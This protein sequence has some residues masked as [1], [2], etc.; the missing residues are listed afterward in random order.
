MVAAAHGVPP[1]WV[2]TIQGAELWAFQMALHNVLFPSHVFTD[3]K[4]VQVGVRQEPQWLRASKRRYARIW[5]VIHA[6][7]DDGASANTMVW[8]PAHTSQDRVGEAQCSDGLVLS[9]DMWQANRM[10]DLLAKEAA[11]RVRQPPATRKWIK[12]HFKRLRDVA[13]FVGQL[14]YEAG[15]HVSPDGTVVRD[16]VGVA[17]M[18]RSAKRVPPQSAVHLGGGLAGEPASG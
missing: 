9:Y 14:T 11:E 12:S 6:A 8:L 15:A 17:C 5:T 7:L 3:C 1:A 4:T 18:A 2:S 10:V 13:V 16:S